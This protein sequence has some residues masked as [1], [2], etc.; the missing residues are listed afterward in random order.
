MDSRQSPQVVDS[1]DLR[2]L[3]QVGKE[4][5]LSAYQVLLEAGVIVADFALNA[6]SDAG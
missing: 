4:K 1:R 3:V 6:G 5:G 2:R